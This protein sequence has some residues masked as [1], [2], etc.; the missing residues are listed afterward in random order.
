MRRAL[1]RA[2]GGFAAAHTLSRF[3]YR[4]LVFAVGLAVVVLA[5]WLCIVHVWHLHISGARVLE[6]LQHPLFAFEG[7]PVTMLSTVFFFLTIAALFVFS[8]RIRGFLEK[9]I[10]PRFSQDIGV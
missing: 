3:A 9:R 5:A 2:P 4:V 1:F 6:V 7:R 8:R 10:M